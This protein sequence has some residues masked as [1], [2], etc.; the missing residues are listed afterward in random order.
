MDDLVRKLALGEL[1]G[2]ELD[3]VLSH[4]ENCKACSEELDVL[5]SLASLARERPEAFLGTRSV[6][7]NREARTPLLA[8]LAAKLGEFLAPLPRSAGILAPVAAVLLVIFAYSSFDRMQGFYG[9]LADLAPSPYLPGNLRGEGDGELFEAAMEDYRRGAYAEASEKLSS[10]LGG[11]EYDEKTGLYL[12]I[13]LLL[14]EKANEAVPHLE[15]AS[16]S[17]NPQVRQKSFWYLAQASLIMEDPLAARNAL[18]KVVV[19]GGGLSDRARAQLRA[20][21]EREW[22]SQESDR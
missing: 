20:I 3:R 6:A 9:P 12:G 7:E 14:S 11:G 13:S 21:E 22:Q 8:R 19:E 4:I 2:S 1:A 17:A 5:A 18:E 16:A 15:R 10:L